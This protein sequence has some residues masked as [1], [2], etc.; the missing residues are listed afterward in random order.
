MKRIFSIVRFSIFL[1][2][3]AAKQRRNAAHFAPLRALREI[4]LGHYRVLSIFFVFLFAILR[5]NAQKEV[6]H[7]IFFAR[8]RERIHEKSFLDN[9]HIIGA[10]LKYDWRELEPR[11]DAYNL[12]LIQKDL[13]YLTSKGKKLFIQLQDVSFD[14]IYK[15]VPDYIM[16]DTV[17]HGGANIQYSTEDNDRIIR[18]GGWMARRWDTAVAHRFYKLL[19]ILGDHFDGKIEGI[20]LPETSA[21]FGET[22]KLFPLGYTH[23]I[24]KNAILD[25]MVTL[26]LAF[27]TS[28]VIQYANFMPG[29]WL[30]WNDKSYL[31]DIYTFA[32]ENG[33]GMGG[34]DI[35]VYNKGHM[36]NGYKFLKEYAKDL[37]TGLAVQDGNYAEINPK[38]GMRVTI[39]EIYDFGKNYIG[40]NYIF[41]CTEE[42][43]YTKEVLPFLGS[44]RSR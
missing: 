33:I 27:L 30:P 19:F 26:K 12:D 29:E 10:Q 31:K 14:T 17:Y 24:Y 35:K 3:F 8:E 23:E 13:D 20:N 42:S 11:K 40:L 39:D 4:I 15:I 21:E 9:P 43:F 18:R 1:A 38:T 5:A 41:W 2:A 44:G 37:I 34:P 16:Q 28:V 6:R 7:F 25:Y 32:K 22:G 36:N